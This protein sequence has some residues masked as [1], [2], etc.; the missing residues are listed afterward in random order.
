MLNLGVTTH[1][2][3]SPSSSISLSSHNIITFLCSDTLAKALDFTIVVKMF[4]VHGKHAIRVGLYR[5]LLM[6]SR[7]IFTET[8]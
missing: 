2:D 4:H 3:L 1:F 5:K 8:L 7:E 6:V